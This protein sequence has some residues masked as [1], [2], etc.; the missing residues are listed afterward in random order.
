[1]SF[2]GV[3]M[4]TESMKDM[5]CPEELSA[6]CRVKVIQD[7]K[8]QSTSNSRLPVSHERLDRGHPMI[9]ADS[10]PQFKGVVNEAIHGNELSLCKLGYALGQSAGFTSTAYHSFIIGKVRDCNMNHE[11]VKDIQSKCYCLPESSDS[12]VRA[13][14]EVA[15]NKVTLSSV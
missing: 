6:E 1:M 14:T 5:T 7:P 8:D 11:E 2:D 15:L 3:S 10:P 4:S 13:L 9:V 12:V